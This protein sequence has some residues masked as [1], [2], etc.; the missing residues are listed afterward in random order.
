MFHP[1]RG[2]LRTCRG[3]CPNHTGLKEAE[4]SVKQAEK[5]QIVCE[6]ELSEKKSAASAAAKTAIEKAKVAL[7]T[8][9]ASVAAKRAER[10]KLAPTR[11][12][13]ELRMIPKH[14]RIPMEQVRIDK[15]NER[16]AAL[17][18]KRRN[19]KR[20]A[21]PVL[22]AG[23]CMAKEWKRQLENEIRTEQRYARKYGGI[24]DMAKL[25]DL[26]QRIR[27][28]DKVIGLSRRKLRKLKAKA[29]GCR[30]KIVKVLRACLPDG[31]REG[32]VKEA[33]CKKKR[34]VLMVEIADV[35][36]E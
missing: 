14:Y 6:Q 13:E 16:L 8:C 31:D 10:E 12:I 17:L 35:I 25:H 36:P 24:V 1:T 2:P 19:D 7:E 9:K 5:K 30:S 23:I 32:T 34:I 15:D 11:T 26:Q 3:C 27:R 28:T 18:E 4:A 33:A 20:W 22:S 21:G 29:S